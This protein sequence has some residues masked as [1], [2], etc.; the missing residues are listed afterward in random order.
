MQA[1]QTSKL[2]GQSSPDAIARHC[3]SAECHL[4]VNLCSEA[5]PSGWRF[6]GQ[7]QQHPE[8]CLGTSELRESTCSHAPTQSF[9]KPMLHR[10]MPQDP[11]SV[12]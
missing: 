6:S 2:G 8:E 11:M 7:T 9:S 12:L 3:C 1:K 10:R 5:G 4:G